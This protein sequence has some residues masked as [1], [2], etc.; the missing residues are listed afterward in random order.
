M[1]PAAQP[2]RTARVTTTA[3]SSTL[4][5]FKVLEIRLLVSSLFNSN[6]E[7]LNNAVGAVPA[8]C[9]FPFQVLRIVGGI[10]AI[11]EM[12]LQILLKQSVYGGNEIRYAILQ[13]FRHV[14]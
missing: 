3:P 5:G 4:R 14:R 7:R 10:R 13:S 11:A 8:F 1:L 9:L 2:G 12:F 6:V